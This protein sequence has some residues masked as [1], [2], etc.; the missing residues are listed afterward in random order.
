MADQMLIVARM[1]PGHADAVAA[2]FAAS[3]AGELPK[4]LGVTRRSLFRYQGLYFHSVEFAGDHREAMRI[5]RDDPEFRQLS[6]QLRPFVTPYD[7]ASWRSPADAMAERFYH[8]AS[9]GSADGQ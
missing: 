2:L 1:A 5:A 7:P 8:W 6:D 4:R 9:P 3:D